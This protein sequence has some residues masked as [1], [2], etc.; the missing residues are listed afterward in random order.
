MRRQ[1][2]RDQRIR[3][4]AFDLALFENSD[5]LERTYKAVQVQGCLAC[6]AAL[7]LGGNYTWSETKG[8]QIGQTSGSGP[9]SDAILRYPEFKAF[10]QNNPVGFLPQD[11]THKARAWVSFDQPLGPAGNL[12]ISVLQN[13]RLRYAV[14]GDR[15]HSDVDP[16]R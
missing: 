16:C 12:N 14:L 8:N 15:E 3:S 10:A 1:A 7:N 6:H 13:Y 4:D 9:V 11:Q 5:V 2:S